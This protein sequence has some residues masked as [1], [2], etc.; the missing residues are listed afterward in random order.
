MGHFDNPNRIKAGIIYSIKQYGFNT[1][2]TYCY[3][4]E[5]KIMFSKIIYNIEEVSFNE[6]L[7]ELIDEGLIRGW[8]LSQVDK[9][10]IKKKHMKLHLY[11]QYKILYNMLERD[12]EE[13]VIPYC[14]KHNI[15]LVPFSPIASGFLSGKVTST[16]QFEK[17]E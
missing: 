16:S 9:K 1:G 11:R 14:L 4:D 5:I 15:G 10:I 17:V 2:S 8:G 13:E 12:C 7:D 3:L 6:Y